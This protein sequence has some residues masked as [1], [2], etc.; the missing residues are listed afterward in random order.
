MSALDVAIKA[1]DELQ[2][3]RQLNYKEENNND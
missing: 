1:L 3:L 2:D